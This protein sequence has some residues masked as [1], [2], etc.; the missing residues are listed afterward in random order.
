MTSQ[1]HR[2]GLGTAQFGLPYGVANHAGQIGAEDA[3]AI[4]AAA[5]VGGIDTLDT[6]VAYGESETRLGEIG[7]MDLRVVTKIPPIEA[8]VV[9][10]HAWVLDSIVGSLG[11]LGLVRCHGVLLH[12]AHD[13][14]GPHGDAARSALEEAKA[15]G[16]VDKI[17]VSIYDPEELE[18]LSRHL[19]LDLIQ[20]PFNVLDRRLA[21]SGWL[22]RLKEGG[23]EVHTRSVF[24]QG[25]LL[26]SDGDRPRRFERWRPLWDGWQHWLDQ[27]RLTPVQGALGFGLGHPQIDRLIVGVDSLR[28]LGEVLAAADGT[29]V[30]LPAGLS[31][32]DPN[33][34]NPSR[35]PTL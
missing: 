10:A 29:A 4:L 26:M 22:A 32:E 33:L 1:A 24:L 12:R 27:H 3:A 11:R 23:T 14:A 5:R 7:V 15:Q 9:D 30:P 18:T 13:L 34:I 2:L 19:P 28:Q 16:Y 25:L 17:G 21:E 6:A 20:A 8:G 31:C 35:W